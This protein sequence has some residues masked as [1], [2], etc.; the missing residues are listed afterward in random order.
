VSQ[1]ADRHHQHHQ[2]PEHRRVED[3]KGPERPVWHQGQDHQRRGQQHQSVLQFPLAHQVAGDAVQRRLG[4]EQDGEHH[5]QA[6]GQRRQAHGQA[7]EQAGE[8]QGDFASEP[9]VLGA[10]VPVAHRHEH[11]QRQHQHQEHRQAQPQRHGAGQRDQRVGAQ[12]RRAR[13]FG[14]AAFSHGADQQA[15]AQRGGHGKQRDFRAQEHAA[16]VALL[17]PALASPARARTMRGSACHP[18]TP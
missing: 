13:G 4:V 5:A 16:I 11:R 1:G 2:L 3:V 15:N 7:A 8:Q 10:G 17:G 12:P 6:T 9:G 14:M 18:G